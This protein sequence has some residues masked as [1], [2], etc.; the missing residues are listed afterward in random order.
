MRRY[1]L[2]RTLSI[3]PTLLGVTLAVFLLIR[4]IP[5]TIVDQMIGT[6]GCTPQILYP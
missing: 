5:G 4:L 2:I 3:L 6:E 1:A